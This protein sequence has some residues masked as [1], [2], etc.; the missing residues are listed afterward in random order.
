MASV[1]FE[2]VV[3]VKTRTVVTSQSSNCFFS[4]QSSEAIVQRDRVNAIASEKNSLAQVSSLDLLIIHNSF[5]CVED[6][7]NVIKKKEPSFHNI[8]SQLGQL[9]WFFLYKR[10]NT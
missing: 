8:S 3:D 9:C 7:C 10:V 4:F 1:S 6:D 5:L 2:F